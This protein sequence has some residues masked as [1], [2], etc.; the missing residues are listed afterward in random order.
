VSDPAPLDLDAINHPSIEEFSQGVQRLYEVSSGQV[1]GI[2]RDAQWHAV[3][4]AGH[5]LNDMYDAV[6]T[7]NAALVAALRAAQ[8]ERDE[9][10]EKFHDEAANWGRSYGDLV[11]ESA[12]SQ[13]A[14]AVL[15]REARE[16]PYYDL[17]DLDWYKR[18][19]AAL[20]KLG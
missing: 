5:R 3:E 6:I 10:K 1:V 13:H 9:W 15:V 7:S 18:A 12:E 4:D 8:R 16:T 19:D 14:L 20:A 11:R 2:G 17:E